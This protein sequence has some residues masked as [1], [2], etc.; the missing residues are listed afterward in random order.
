MMSAEPENPK[1]HKGVSGVA[2][3]AGLFIGMG[4]GFAVDE[5]VAGLF[6]GLGAG[7]LIMLIVR[8]KLGEW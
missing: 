4:I 2:I 3:P 7:F 1:K 8:A 6:I 5:L